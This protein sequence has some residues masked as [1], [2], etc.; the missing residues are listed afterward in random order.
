MY[1]LEYLSQFVELAV[2]ITCFLQFL[3]FIFGSCWLFI[4]IAEDLTKDST[5]FNDA[6]TKKDDAND[7]ELTKQ[8]CDL[9]QIYLDAKQ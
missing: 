3:N 6:I 5:A 8:F 7:A 4:F 2:F 1:L 9:V